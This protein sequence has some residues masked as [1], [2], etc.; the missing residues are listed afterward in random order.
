MPSLPPVTNATSPLGVQ[1]TFPLGFSALR[2]TVPFSRITSPA[3]NK[4]RHTLIPLSVFSI[5]RSAS[6]SIF[7]SG[8]RD[9]QAKAP[10][11]KPDSKGLNRV[12][13]KRFTTRWRDM[14]VRIVCIGRGSLE[15]G[16]DLY[17][18]KSFVT[19]I[20]RHQSKQ[21]Q[22]FGEVWSVPAK[23]GQF[24]RTNALSDSYTSSPKM[25]SDTCLN[26]NR[27][28]LCPCLSGRQQDT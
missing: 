20:K 7:P 22:A 11:A 16:L 10:A 9:R 21:S 13:L 5:A 28:F 27:G 1:R 18:Y 2:E 6:L 23:R 24:S 3:R 14:Y 19:W 8:C 4:P 26:Q 12:A 17:R 25:W 15:S